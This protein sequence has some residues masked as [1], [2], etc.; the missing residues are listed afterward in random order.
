MTKIVMVVTSADYL[1]LKNGAHSTGSWA[2]EVVVPYETFRRAGVDVDI[3]T[4]DGDVAHVDEASLSPEMNGG[5][6]DRVAYL[7]E[8]LSDMAPRLE[9]PQR[10]QDVAARGAADANAVFIPGGHGPMAD[11]PGSADLGRILIN[12]CDGGKPVVAVCHGPAGLLAAERD[13]AWPFAGFQLTA[14]TNEEERQTGLA[15]KM[16][17]L[18]ETR[19]RSYNA[20]FQAGPAWK[21]HVVTDRNLITGQNPQSARDAAERVLEMLRVTVGT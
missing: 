15:D 3:A 16:T 6:T 21:S 11:L 12:M 13:G 19:L 20:D 14:F 8:R 5:D 2:E 7:R 9:S 4:P 10:L 1:S 18:L 17:W